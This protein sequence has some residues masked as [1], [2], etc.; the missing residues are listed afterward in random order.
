MLILSGIVALIPE[1]LIYVTSD[2]AVRL[3]F[4]L[5]WHTLSVSGSIVPAYNLQI[6]SSDSLAD[7][8]QTKFEFFRLDCACVQS[9]DTLYYGFAFEDAVIEPRATT[10]WVGD[11]RDVGG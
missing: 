1:V 11:L 5:R 3:N 8:W 2:C 7:R 10:F 9:S 6:H 4:Q